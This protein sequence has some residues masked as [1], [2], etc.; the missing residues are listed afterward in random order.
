MPPPH[1]PPPERGE[2]ESAPSTPGFRRHVGKLFWVGVAIAP[3]AALLLVLGSGVGPLRAAAVL[4]VFSVVIIGLSVVLRDDAAMVKDDVEEQL[5][6][7]VTQ[8]R[9]DIDSLR[10]GVEV[11]VHRELERVHRELEATR[12][13]G[14]LR[15]ESTR[16]N[17][18]TGALPAG[19]DDYPV[20]SRGRGDRPMRAIAAGGEIPDAEPGYDWFGSDE[21]GAGQ[22]QEPIR[23][24]A[25]TYGSARPAGSSDTGDNPGNWPR[26]PAEPEPAASGRRAGGNEYGGTEYGRRRPDADDSAGRYQSYQASTYGSGTGGDAPKEQRSGRRRAPEEDSAGYPVI[27]YDDAPPAYTPQ[28]IDAGVYGSRSTDDR[29]KD[30]SGENGT[31]DYAEFWDRSGNSSEGARNESNR[32][33][34]NRREAPRRDAEPRNADARNADPRSAD[35]RNGDPRNGAPRNAA[36]RNADPRGADPRN[37]GPRSESSRD[38][39]R[40][41]A[42]E[43]SSWRENT[44]GWDSGSYGWDTGSQRFNQED[45]QVITGAITGDVFDV[46]YSVGGQALSEPAFGSGNGFGAGAGFGSGNGFGAQQRWDEL[47]DVAPAPEWQS[48]SH[49]SGPNSTVAEPS[50]EF[51]LPSL[52]HLPQAPSGG[53]DDNS[54][55]RRARHAS[56]DEDSGRYKSW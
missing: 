15:A 43:W 41:S 4:A 33:E 12:R 35:S 39:D 32:N 9:N 3:L 36:P 27:D 49:R 56:I 47:P 53:S 37:A 46:P 51:E 19:E 21:T 52:E 6:T 55:E 30:N 54:A 50:A 22:R 23:Y 13:E 1:L 26:R 14:V 28:R 31:I 17:R 44:N 7:E 34:S 40:S 38:P 48:A 24:G 18:L 42:S 20:D 10:R 8:L 25:G 45:P 5:R 29:S 11:S 16:L 2:S